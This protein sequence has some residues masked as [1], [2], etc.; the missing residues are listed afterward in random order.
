MR[1]LLMDSMTQITR[2]KVLRMPFI[3]QL[4]GQVVGIVP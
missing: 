4:K 3:I 2:G 1:G